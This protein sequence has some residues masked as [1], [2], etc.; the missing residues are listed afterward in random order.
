MYLVLKKLLVYLKN[1]ASFKLQQP[2]DFISKP[3]LSHK[4]TDFMK[5]SGYRV[6]AA[7]FFGKT[8]S[9]C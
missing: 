4:F 3:N 6:P 2:L 5:A 7:T 8:S 1:K 9:I